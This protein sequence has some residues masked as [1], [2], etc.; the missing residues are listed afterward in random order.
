MKKKTYDGREVTFITEN[1]QTDWDWLEE[2]EKSGKAHLLRPRDSKSYSLMAMELKVKAFNP[3]IK[4]QLSSTILWLGMMLMIK[5]SHIADQRNVILY[6]NLLI[7]FNKY[8]F[9]S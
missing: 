9:V 6:L 5:L 7:V 4:A 8:S 2:A 3:E 1:T